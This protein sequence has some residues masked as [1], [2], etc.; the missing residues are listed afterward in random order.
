MLTFT[1]QRSVGELNVYADDADLF[2]W[3]YLPG[4]PTI[5]KDDRGLPI[6]SLM[7]YRRNLDSLTEEE[8]RTHLG[9]GL[10]T[11]TAMLSAT[12][13]E[14]DAIL[15]AIVADPNFR[16]SVI[17]DRLPQLGLTAWDANE[18]RKAIKLSQ[19]PAQDGTVKVGVLGETTG[20]TGEFVT[21]LIGGG[22]ANL[23]GN[24]RVAVTAKL[25]IDGAIALQR[26][27]E[28]NRPG[29]YLQY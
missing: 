21:A 9:G 11:F 1:G 22:R 5:A 15:D 26:L 12:Q 4:N 2:Q 24:H 18:V 8:R 3:Y 7:V 20:T 23:V 28:A 6:L 14:I 13:P 27:L 25:T 19:A 16:A 10:L 17:R 29:L